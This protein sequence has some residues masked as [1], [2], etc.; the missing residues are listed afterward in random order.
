MQLLIFILILGLLIFFH[1][2]GHFLAARAVGIEVEEFGLG[3][4]PRALKLFTWKGTIFS[5]NWIPFG[6][7]CRIKGETDGDVPTGFLAAPAWKRFVIA[8]SGPLFNLIIGILVLTFMFI[9]IGEPVNT[10]VMIADIAA[11]SPA[12]QAGILPG[13]AV[14]AVNQQP[15]KDIGDLQTKISKNAGQTVTLT[16]QRADELL[17][18][19]LVPRLNPPPGEGSMGV[20]TGYA[21]P[22]EL[23]ATPFFKAMGYAFEA[24]Y[25]QI[26]EVVLLPGR[27][28][29]GSIQPEQARLSGF[30]GMYDMFVWSGEVDNATAETG[31]IKINYTQFMLVGI[32]SIALGFT[33]LLPIPALD[34]GRIIFLLPEVL[35]KKRIPV[36]FENTIN[37]IFFILL[38]VLVIIIN[39]NDFINELQ[40]PP[41]TP[42]P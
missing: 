29:N 26:R 33:N 24:G 20:I 22:V 32:I 23:K 4:P 42:T 18:L 11:N 6:G 37:T 1:E 9:A 25:M 36:R 19:S 35:F 15:V 17:T 12:E 28:I 13:D 27:L 2:M 8:F 16:I 10:T 5:I 38:I 21:Q 39:A 7:F 3:F 34:G 14:L 30:K 40:L 41:I 31:F